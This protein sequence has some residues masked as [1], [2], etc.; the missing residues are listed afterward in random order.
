[1]ELSVEQKWNHKNQIVDSGIFI[2][3]R[4]TFNNLVNMNLNLG[5]FPSIYD[6]INSDGN[7]TFKFVDQTF[8]ALNINSDASRRFSM[9]LNLRRASEDIEGYNYGGAVAV[10]WRATNQLTV[11][12][13]LDYMKR[14]GWLVHQKERDFTTFNAEF[15]QPSFNL[16]YFFSAKQQFRIAF[17]WV[18]VSAVEDKFFVTPQKAGKLIEVS[19]GPAAESDDFSI[20]NLNIQVRYRWELAPLSDLF[21]VYT[22]TADPDTVANRSFGGLFSDALSEPVGE[23]LVLKLRYRLGS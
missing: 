17:Q 14:K 15:W 11:S 20:S 22:R 13:K 18:G 23:E 10:T 5:F 2:H 1:M 8:V 6:D 4:V 16:D 19:R 9:G 7:G 3:Q 12:A 21:L